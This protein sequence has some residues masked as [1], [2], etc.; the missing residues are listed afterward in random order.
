MASSTPHGNG[1][2][3]RRAGMVTLCTVSLV[4]GLGVVDPGTASARTLKSRQLLS[5]TKVV[6]GSN[7]RV[8]TTRVA[9]PRVPVA[10]TAAPSVAP[11][12]APVLAPVVD[13]VVAP[14]VQA[15]AA[16]APGAFVLRE[17]VGS[18]PVADSAGH[19]FAPATGVV[20]GSVA[21]RSTS[22]PQTGSSALYSAYRAGITSWT[23]TVPAPGRYAVDVLTAPLPGEERGVRV[24]DLTVNGQTVVPA[25]DARDLAPEGGPA[26]ATAVVD[27]A[28]TELVLGF[29]ARAG[30]PVVSSLVVAS[31]GPAGGGSTTFAE[32]FDGPAGA[33]PSAASW[34]ADAG[35]G[36]DGGEQVYDAAANTLTG[37]G[38]L[39]ITA[40]RTASGYRSGRITSKGKVTFG[41]GTVAARMKLPAGTG[42]WPA[43]WALGADI[44]AV[45]W[46][47]CGEIDI[48]EH[49]G[50]WPLD[51]AA[52]VHSYGVAGDE[53]TSY[54]NQP[55]ATI[56]GMRKPTGTPLADAYHDYGIVYAPGFIT[57][58][59]DGKAFFTASQVDLKAGQSWPFT[60]KPSFLLLNLAVG[61][62][63][64]GSPDASTPWPATL[65]VDRVRITD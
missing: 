21:T 6:G 25:V 52:N 45:D 24:F 20:G 61:G 49:L 10:P 50:K 11:S 29:P 59:L 17:T 62:S 5:A 48:V 3:R 63:W 56:G 57:F 64:G 7:A 35:T 16:L 53:L 27:T 54:K 32:D 22:V 34:T 1:Q 65:L 23:V 15:V 19:L 36:F 26:H 4:V 39:A 55:M 31:D 18:L 8:R 2:S 28:S 43:F 30:A 38:Q 46:P 37:A 14:V 13:P 40:T 44:D 9:R 60:G 47:R 12:L 58:T 33:A 51:A 42:L 41:Y